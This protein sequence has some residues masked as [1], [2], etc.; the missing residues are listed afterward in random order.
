MAITAWGDD[1]TTPELDGMSSGD[2][3]I[4]GLCI[5][6]YEDFF[7]GVDPSMSSSGMFTETYATNA[8]ASLEGINFAS[9]DNCVSCIVENCWPININENKES[10]FLLRRVDIFGRTIHKNNPKGLY[11][12]VFNDKSVDKKFVF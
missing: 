2:P 1:S 11:F 6:G 9:Y 3:Y 8:F 4:F 10:R 7:I 12:E 5:E